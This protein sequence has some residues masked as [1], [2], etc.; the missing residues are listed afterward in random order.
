[1]GLLDNST[2]YW[3]EVKKV[4]NRLQEWGVNSVKTVK[5]LGEDHLKLGIYDRKGSQKAT[6][7]IDDQGNLVIDETDP[8]DVFTCFLS[9]P[10]TPMGSDSAAPQQQTQARFGAQQNS[11]PQPQTR[12]SGTQMT[13]LQAQ[14]R[15]N[16][17]PTVGSQGQ[18]RPN[19]GYQPQGQPQAQTR[20]APAPVSSAQGYNRTAQPTQGRPY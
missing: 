11:A 18:A 16:A 6:A 5:Y 17:A 1:M 10:G 20:P 3:E 4:H 2:Y 14:G 15:V 7:T 12:L 13:G 8:M 9:Q 19:Q